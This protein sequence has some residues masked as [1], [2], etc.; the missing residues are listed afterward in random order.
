M[1]DL[2]NEERTEGS[3]IQPRRQNW[4]LPDIWNWDP[5]RNFFSNAP[6][7]SGL[8]ISRT[9]RGY[10]VEVPVAGYRPEDIDV[11]LENGVLQVSG[12]TEKRSFARSFVLP[13]EIDENNIDA[14]VEHGLLTLTLNLLPKAQPKK[15]SVKTSG[16]GSQQS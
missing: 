11:T 8:D 4:G 2:A 14:K 15:I 3:D 16:G 7:L 9:D 10:V 5:F 12:K 1:N 6:V 13:E